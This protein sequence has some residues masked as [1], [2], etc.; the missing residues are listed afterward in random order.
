[1][2][3]RPRVYIA[4][5]YSIG[6]TNRNVLNSLNAF[7]ELLTEGFSPFSPLAMN[8]FVDLVH[9]RNYED[10]MTYDLEWVATCDAVLRLQG[11]SKGAD[12]E[13][14]YA[15]GIGIPVFYGFPDLMRWKREMWPKQ[16][17]NDL[18]FALRELIRVKRAPILEEL[19][20][21]QKIA[22][23][24]ETGEIVP[25]RACTEIATRIGLLGMQL[26]KDADAS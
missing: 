15:H 2:N 10:W 17:E 21:L 22:L 11:E 13:V 24:A 8:H 19:S 6:N 12:R 5:P 26:K 9:P 23:A 16:A 7:D 18:A 25:F 3:R 20:A 4:S 1:M 14:R